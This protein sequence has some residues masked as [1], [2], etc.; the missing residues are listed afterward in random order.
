MISVKLCEEGIRPTW[1]VIVMV[2]FLEEELRAV[3][4]I[5]T[6]EARSEIVFRNRIVVGN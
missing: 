4:Q 1:T 3:S 5:I 6:V 2:N